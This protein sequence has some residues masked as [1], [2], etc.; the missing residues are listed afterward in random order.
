VNTFY[1]AADSVTSAD[2]PVGKFRMVMGYVNGK[3]AWSQADISRHVSH[4]TL[5]ASIDVNGTHPD[6]DI[7]DVENGDATPEGAVGWVRTKLTRHDPY[8]PIIYCSRSALTAVF[9][10]LQAAGFFPGKHFRTGIA[11]WNDNDQNPAVNIHDMTGVTYIQYKDSTLVGAHYDLC[12]VYD[13][14]WKQSAPPPPPPPATQHGVVVEL[15]GS[16]AAVPV[17]TSDG[18]LTWKRS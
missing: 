5:Y 9:N 7:L 14:T 18:G 4:G 12:A 17:T 8:L 16:N 15:Y 11:D 3:Y 10:A 6:A 1:E 13:P 2:I